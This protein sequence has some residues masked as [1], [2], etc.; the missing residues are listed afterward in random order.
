MRL[1]STALTRRVLLVDD[2]QPEAR[3]LSGIIGRLQCHEVVARAEN[4][5]EGL[6]LFHKLAPDIVCMDIVM[7][8]MD[9]LQAGRAILRAAPETRLY[10]ISSVG[11]APSRLAEAIEMGARNVLAKPFRPEDVFAM[12][13]VDEPD[14]AP[15]APLA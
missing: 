3:E 15:Y 9:G 10:M 14:P 6:K 13:L 8:V 12:L 11:D 4:G 2:S 1:V 7:P 5:A